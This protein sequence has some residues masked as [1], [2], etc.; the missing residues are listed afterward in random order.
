MSERSYYEN[1]GGLDEERYT[2][3]LFLDNPAEMS[4]F[5]KVIELLP[6]DTNTLLDVGCGQGVFLH[7]LKT[8]TPISA[9]GLERSRPS[10]KVAKRMFGG[11]VVEGEANKLP[12]ASRTFDTLVSLEVIEHLPYQIY[13]QSLL[14]MARVARNCV[15]I[16]VP[17]QEY[18]TFV[19]CPYCG[20]RFHSAYHMRSFDENKLKTLFDDFELSSSHKFHAEYRMF[21]HGLIANL[22]KRRYFPAFAI[23]PACGYKQEKV[24]S[25][26]ATSIT[27]Q[28][29]EWI[30]KAKH[31][32]NSRWI[33]KRLTYRWIL[34][35]YLRK[36]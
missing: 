20:C 32:V 31:L 29:G 36:R 8:Q 28:P 17:Y 33:P 10:V 34:G 1:Y 9:V 19:T 30:A 26:D 7:L 24:V 13:E 2:Q 35:V 6:S 3:E 5:N 16:G 25:A 23:C 22:Y 21:G 12:F 15:V 18:R 11:T 14:E 27:P 4:R